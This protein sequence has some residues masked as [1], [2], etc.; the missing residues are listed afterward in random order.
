MA[1]CSWRPGRSTCSGTG[2]WSSC[3]AG[4]A[5]AWSACAGRRRS[6]R[7]PGDLDQSLA[8]SPPAAQ[9]DHGAGGRR[10]AIPIA[11][12]PE[13]AREAARGGEQL[14]RRRAACCVARAERVG[15]GVERVLEYAPRHGAH[16]GLL[17][18]S[19]S[20]LAFLRRLRQGP[21][22][23]MVVGKLVTLADLVASSSLW[24]SPW[25]HLDTSLYEDWGELL[26][27]AVFLG[28]CIFW[29][30]MDRRS[31]IRLWLGVLAVVIGVKLVLAD[32]PITHTVTDTALAVPRAVLRLFR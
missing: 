29:G 26:L 2:A 32:G 12:Q 1:G 31:S 10:H 17:R 6:L 14:E 3:S 23:G 7:G 27:V 4:A 9:L 28:L 16:L 24:V 25:K 22:R 21:R 15:A 11:A 30:L 5:T 20:A 13:P 19:P 18:P 8:S